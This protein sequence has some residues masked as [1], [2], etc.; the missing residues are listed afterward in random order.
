MRQLNSKLGFHLRRECI[1]EFPLYRL[2]PIYNTE[3][4]STFKLSS[5]L[6]QGLFQ[7]QGITLELNRLQVAVHTLVTHL[8]QSLSKW[9]NWCCPMATHGANGLIK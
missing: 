6:D 7:M 4:T 8:K 5:Q 2:F 3:L 9:Y 1:G